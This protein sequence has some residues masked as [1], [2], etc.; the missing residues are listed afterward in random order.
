MVAYASLEM[1]LKQLYINENPDKDPPML[2]ALLKY[3]R[4]SGWLKNE[5]FSYREEIAYRKA[6]QNEMYDVIQSGVLKKEGDSI[7]IEE[8]PEEEI[9]AALDSLDLVGKFVKAAPD[10]RNTLAHGSNMLHPNSI[11]TLQHIAAAINM[12]YK[13]SNNTA[14]PQ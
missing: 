14:L 1:A 13:N 5:D 10:L 3:A 6:R 8:S 2:R 4:T 12:A 11:W 7:P 9:K